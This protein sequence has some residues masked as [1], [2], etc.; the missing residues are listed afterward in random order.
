MPGVRMLSDFKD[1]VKI[2]GLRGLYRGFTPFFISQL[3][4]GVE[5]TSSPPSTLMLKA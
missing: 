5:F 2:G 1:I 3:M 4:N